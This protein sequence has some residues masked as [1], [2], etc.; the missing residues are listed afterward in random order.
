MGENS[1]AT[2]TET[3]HSSTI[4]TALDLYLPLFIESTF[5][6]SFL[7]KTVVM[8][9]PLVDSLSPEWLYT[10]S[11]PSDYSRILK[12][13]NITSFDIRGKNFFCGNATVQISYIGFSNDYAAFPEH[14]INYFIFYCAQFLAVPF[15]RDD[16][17]TARIDEM[18]KL[19]K[20]V[21]EAVESRLKGGIRTLLNQNTKMGV[22]TQVN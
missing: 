8:D 4:S 15:T 1:V 17:I 2:P 19:T 5:D 7:R 13:F 14:F 9:T 3:G 21:A 11:L 18:L 20:E 16:K 10:F 22:Y 6:W 12:V